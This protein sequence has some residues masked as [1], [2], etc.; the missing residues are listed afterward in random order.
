MIVAGILLFS[1]ASTT[2]LALLLWESHYEK[3]RKRI[4]VLEEENLRL[5]D[6]LNLT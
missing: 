2:L 6:R 1:G 5:K 4:K 3:L